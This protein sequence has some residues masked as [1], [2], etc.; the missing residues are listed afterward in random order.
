MTGTHFIP[1]TSKPIGRSQGH[2]VGAAAKSMVLVA[3]FALLLGSCS[4][5][6]ALQITDAWWLTEEYAATETK[7]ES[8]PVGQLNKEWVRA[9][10]LSKARLSPEGQDYLKK[11]LKE[12]QDVYFVLRDDFNKDGVQDEALVGVYETKEGKKGRFLLILSHTQDQKWK[13][14]YLE[15]DRSK[16]GF[17]ALLYREG[18]L[19][20]I[21]CFECDGFPDVIWSKDHYELKY[22]EPEG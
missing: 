3:F 10:V 19:S 14:D 4:K 11:R 20:W 7:I 16:P 12:K 5:S 17:S 18:K 15:V 1:I 21:D 22:P 13:K 6:S 9:S 8:I 2:A